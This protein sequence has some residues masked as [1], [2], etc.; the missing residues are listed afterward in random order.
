M[1]VLRGADK[2]IDMSV[3][4]QNGFTV[5]HFQWTDEGNIETIINE[6]G[7]ISYELL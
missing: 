5:G 2:N 1:Q 4:M 6:T 3:R 7:L